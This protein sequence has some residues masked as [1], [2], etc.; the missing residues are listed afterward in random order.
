MWSDSLSCWEYLPEPCCVVVKPLQYFSVRQKL[1]SCA[2]SSEP[3]CILPGSFLSL[4]LS[5]L[6]T[7]QINPLLLSSGISVRSR[8]VNRFTIEQDSQVLNI[9]FSYFL[10]H[11]FHYV[12]HLR[13]AFAECEADTQQ[14]CGH[15]PSSGPFQ[16]SQFHDSVRF[17]GSSCADQWH[18]Q[19]L[20]LLPVVCAPQCA[21]LFGWLCRDQGPF[22]QRGASWMLWERAFMLCPFSAISG[23]PIWSPVLGFMVHRHPHTLLQDGVFLG[24]LQAKPSLQPALKP[25]AKYLS[26]RKGEIVRWI[27]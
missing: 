3:F 26:E 6:E 19:T 27:P 8:T 18:S 1:G 24:G 25:A 7:P 14:W 16:P 23:K 9:D 12:H 11:I 22:V 5:L 2:R 20:E 17:D 10:F 13:K 21:R 15:K 4:S